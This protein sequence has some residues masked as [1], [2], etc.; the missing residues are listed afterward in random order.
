[1]EQGETMSREELAQAVEKARLDQ[2]LTLKEIAARIGR[3]IG[4]VQK[5]RHG[6]YVSDRVLARVR[7]E[8]CH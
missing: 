1:M 5:I 3:S 4:T 6:G 8:F 2:D 7:S